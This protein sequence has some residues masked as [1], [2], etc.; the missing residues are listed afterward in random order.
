MMKFVS[1][2][3]G[4]LMIWLALSGCTGAEATPPAVPSMM[5]TAA[6][7]A[8]ADLPPSP[9]ATIADPPPLPTAEPTITAVIATPT[10]TPPPTETPL[11]APTVPALG[12]TRTIGY[13][14]EGRP[15][16]AYQFKNG[17]TQIIFVGGLHG[18]YEWN[19]IEL[20][21]L[22]IDYFLANPDEV[23]DSVTLIIIPSANPDGQFLVTGKEGRI[24]AADVRVDDTFPGRFNGRNVDLNRNWDCRWASTGVW[25]DETVSGGLQPFSEPE[26]VTLRNFIVGQN[27]AAVVFWHSAFR[28]VFA[29]GC[30]DPYAPSRRLAD[31]YGE[32]SGYP[33]YNQFGSYPVTGDA[34]DWLAT[35][36]IPSISIELTNHQNT[37][38]RQN[39]AG[40]LAVLAYYR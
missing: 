26:T 21:Y 36:N 5:P 32:A 19:T 34:G 27:P 37:D 2:L 33:V 4:C 14:Y 25:R 30:P 3:A 11:P 35:Q 29:S 6:L 13:S 18:G 10:A 22:A 20:A 1:A 40:M 24:T 28:G 39:L 9:T 23:P 8:T 38:W 31:I 16:V 7:P 17:P 15:L 12:I